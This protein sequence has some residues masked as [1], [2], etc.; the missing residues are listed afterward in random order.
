MPSIKDLLGMR[1]QPPRNLIYMELDIPSVKA[2]VR[3]RQISFLKKAKN[4]TYFEGS[5]LQKAIQMTKDCQS[6]M[7]QY[8]KD[9]E[10]LDS[11]PVDEVSKIIKDSD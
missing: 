10:A 4:S 11:D 2:L 6:P 8:I 5:P 3:R 9:L 7:G 1:T